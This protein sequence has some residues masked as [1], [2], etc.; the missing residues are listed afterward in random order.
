MELSLFEFKVGIPLEVPDEFAN[1]LHS[2]YPERYYTEE[3]WK[4]YEKAQDKKLKTIEEEDIPTLEQL[5]DEEFGDLKA[6]ANE[7]GLPFSSN[8]EKKTLATSIYYFLKANAEV[9]EDE[10]PGDTELDLL[11]A[12]GIESLRAKA[13]ELGITYTDG[14]QP[15]TIAKKILKAEE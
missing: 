8:V 3:E 13:N 14:T 2:T 9:A 12:E 11:E 10:A 1:N 7:L 5:K 15:K 4:S 6:Y